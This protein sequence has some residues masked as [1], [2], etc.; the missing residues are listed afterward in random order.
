[1][2]FNVRGCKQTP[3]RNMRLMHLFQV[4]NTIK[5]KLNLSK[6][7]HKSLIFWTNVQPKASH[8]GRKMERGEVEGVNTYKCGTEE[9]NPKTSFRPLPLQNRKWLLTPFAQSAFHGSQYN[10]QR[11]FQTKRD[12]KSI[13]APGTKPWISLTD[14]LSSKWACRF[15]SMSTEVIFK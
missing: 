6:S 4:I 7:T 13:S 14:L 8:Y 9:Y 10:E 12:P 11:P 5:I 2:K 3:E 15:S 1:M